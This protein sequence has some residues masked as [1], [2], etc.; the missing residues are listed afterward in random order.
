MSM[1]AKTEVAKEGHSVLFYIDKLLTEHLKGTTA[2][3]LSLLGALFSDAK[4]SI[5]V[6]LA[7]VSARLKSLEDAAGHVELVLSKMFADDDHYAV[8]MFCAVVLI[9]C[10]VIL[11]KFCQFERN[12]F[13]RL[14]E[15]T[16]KSYTSADREA[17]NPP[18]AMNFSTTQ[19]RVVPWV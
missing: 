7:G 9:I 4:S 11:I 2:V 12:A 3:T 8:Y 17:L 16:N 6:D 14:D 18:S 5:K 1:A 10:C 13:T 15:Y 19:E